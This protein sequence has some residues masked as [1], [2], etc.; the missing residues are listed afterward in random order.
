MELGSRLVP[1]FLKINFSKIPAPAFRYGYLSV[2]FGAAALGIGS[3]CCGYCNF[4]TIPRLIGAPFSSADLAYFMRT[5]GLI[6]LGLVLVLGFF[7]KGGRAYCNLLCPIGALDGL[8]NRL[9]IKWGRR[10]TVQSAQCS[11]CGACLEK[12][13]TW[14]IEIEERKAK[15][16]ALSC[17]PCGACETTCVKGAITYG[18]GERLLP[19]PKVRTAHEK[20]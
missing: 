2:Y 20:A 5:A 18:R 6:N 14:A 10:M 16:D 7:A 1:R 12:C 9:G 19:A 3:L 15:I 4:A 8:A 11:G 13:P 17:I